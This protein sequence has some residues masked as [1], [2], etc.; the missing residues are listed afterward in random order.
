MDNLSLSIILPL[1]SA[2]VKD[3]GDFFKKSIE[4]IKNNDVK[5]KELIIVHTPEEQLISFLDTFDFGDLEEI[6]RA[7]CRE[8]V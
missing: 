1:K 7:S 4:S 5:P 2:V 3:F 6:G 8:R